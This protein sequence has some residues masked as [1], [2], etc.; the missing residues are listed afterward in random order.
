MTWADFIS[1]SEDLLTLTALVAVTY[2]GVEFVLGLRAARESRRAAQVA[3]WRKASVQRIVS[4]SESFMTTGE[5]TAALRSTS[6]DEPFDIKKAELTDESVRL[7]M[8][9]LVR[10]GVLGQVWP[11]SYGITQLPRDITLPVVA[12][13]VRGNMAVRGAFA[14]IH[15]HP[16]HYTD[17]SL[18]EKLRDQ[19]GLS[20]PDFVLAVSDLDQ[21]KVATKG[22]DGKWSPVVNQIL[23]NS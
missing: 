23:G 19:V 15:E 21:R 2:A 7:L 1:Y 16:G 4:K 10:D 22:A 20:L 6:F 17:Q 8:L 14:L 11:D 3:S 5:I 13:G 9:E 18:H 12:A